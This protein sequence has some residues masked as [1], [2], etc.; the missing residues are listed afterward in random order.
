LN[1]LT[2]CRNCLC[3]TRDAALDTVPELYGA[4]ADRADDLAERIADAIAYVERLCVVV[5]GD[6][7]ANV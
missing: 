2:T 4:R 7:R 6:L 5:E 3:D 1:K